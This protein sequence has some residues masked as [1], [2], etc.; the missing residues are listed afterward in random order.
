MK[1]HPIRHASFETT[2]SAFIQILHHSSVSWKITPLY[3]FSPNL[4]YFGQKYPFQVKFSD[5]WVVGGKLFQFLMSY[6]K[7]VVSFYLNVSFFF[8]FNESPKFQTFDCSGQISPN[9]YLIGYFCW[10]YIKFI[11][12]DLKKYRWVRFLDTEESCKIWR[13][14]DL[15]FGKWHEEFNKFSSEH[16]KVSK[17]VLSWLL[18]SKV[19]DA[20]ARNLQRSYV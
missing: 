6:L 14:N 18:L 1:V 19:K 3:F 10:K 20:W 16:L 4:I 11:T 7:P 5:F 9:L 8:F 17:L 13:K 2:R 12:F 15:L